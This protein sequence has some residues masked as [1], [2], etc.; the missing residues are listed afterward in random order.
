MLRES[1]VLQNGVKGFD[2]D[3]TLDRRLGGS[4]IRRAHIP[5]SNSED[6]IS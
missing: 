3:D 1:P 4:Q 6:G 5:D 2:D